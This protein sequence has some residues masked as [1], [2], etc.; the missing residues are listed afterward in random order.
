[1][2]KYPYKMKPLPYAYDYLEPYIDKETM[3]L[4]YDKH[5]RS[6][7]E[8]LNEALKDYPAQQ[9][10]TLTEL[11]SNPETIP[12]S[13]RKAVIDNGGGVYNHERFFKIMGRNANV[14]PN[15]LLKAI[16]NEF[17]SYDKFKTIFKNAALKRFGSG[18]VWLAIN[19]YNELMVVSTPNQN[20]ILE[21]GLK[22]I[23]LL[24]LWEHAYYLKY[25][26]RRGEYIDNWL[27]VL[28]WNN[29]RI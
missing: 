4:H 25:Q 18:W 5:Y 11:L 28:N 15:D 27:K 12:L 10:R 1:M 26:N 14:P 19:D 6:Y 23:I 13:I 17:G 16:T 24:D 8:K 20:T 9:S 7:V 21:L 3:E 22:P 2:N 29:V